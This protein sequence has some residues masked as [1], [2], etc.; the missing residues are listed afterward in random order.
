MKHISNGI[1]GDLAK[2]NPDHR[3]QIR[4]V[5]GRDTTSTPILGA[6]RPAPVRDWVRKFGPRRHD[7]LPPPE[8]PRGP[9]KP[10]HTWP[11][12]APF[13]AESGRAVPARFTMPSRTGP[14]R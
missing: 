8:M 7:P 1:A 3:A 6:N 12:P 2:L 4:E 11:A 9:Q 10:A 5:A 13:K 14:G